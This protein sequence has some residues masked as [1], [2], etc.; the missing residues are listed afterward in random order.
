MPEKALCGLIAR[1]PFKQ[2]QNQFSQVHEAVQLLVPM[3]RSALDEDWATAASTEL[4]VREL[5]QESERVAR[6]ICLHLPNTL[7]M[8]IPRGDILG[9]VARPM[10]AG[11][12]RQRDCP[13]HCADDHRHPCRASG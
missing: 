10:R 1:S 3:L 13:P 12:T 11:A 2:L 5:N 8:P 6:D 9:P 4:H 7:F